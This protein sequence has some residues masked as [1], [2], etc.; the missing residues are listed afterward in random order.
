MAIAAKHQGGVAA[1]WLGLL[2]LSQLG[3]LAVPLPKHSDAIAEV[4]A[5]LRG[6]IAQKGRYQ[7]ILGLLEHLLVYANGD[8]SAMAF[9]TPRSRHCRTRGRR[10]QFSSQM[11]LSANLPHGRLAS[12]SELASQRRR[13]LLAVRFLLVSTLRYPVLNAPSRPMRH[14]RGRCDLASADTAV[15]TGS[16]FRSTAATSAG[17]LKFRSRCSGSLE[18][19]LAFALLCLSSAVSLPALR[20]VLARLR[21]SALCSI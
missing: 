8:R 18:S 3:A 17:H 15:V 2:Q 1:V 19:L 10:P 20:S 6:E 7:S 11:I 9:I 14:R 16:G 4:R 12:L 21:R 5:L 13:S